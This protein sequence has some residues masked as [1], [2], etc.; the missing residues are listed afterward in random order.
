MA[1]VTDPP[2]RR[3]IAKYGR[4]DVFY[5]EFVAADGLVHPKGREK[6]I[7]D[8]AYTEEERPIVAQL[9]SGKPEKI[10]EAAKLV[11]HLG[12]D[13]LDINMGCPDRSIEKQGAGAAL[14]KY[15]KRAQEVLRAA[16]EG[17]EGPVSVK[18]RIGYNN[19]EEGEA[20]IHALT[21]CKP[22][23]MT[24]H[25]RTRKEMS[26][27]PAHWE[28]AG[29]YSQMLENLSIVK[30][31]NGDV[32]SLV[33]AREKAE[34]YNLDGIMIGR[35]IFKDVGLFAEKN[36][37]AEEKLQILLEHTKLFEDY[38]RGIKSFAVMRRFFKIY[39]SGHPSAKELQ[40]SLMKCENFKE[41]EA[42]VSRFA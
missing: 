10:F 22:S 17:F 2:F 4:P 40:E 34:R 11:R 12:F 28:L 20:W 35:G 24:L 19:L 14:I 13:G 9:F 39:T 1:D 26:K 30:I 42:A 3:I 33:E 37:S 41:V 32:E 23:A 27:V 18:T 38:F 25:L 8:L 21:E 6:L 16:Q 31:G 36:F 5:T 15:P 29:I 7:K